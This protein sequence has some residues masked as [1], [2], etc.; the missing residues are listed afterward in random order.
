M[1]TSSVVAPEYAR[2]VADLRRADRMGPPPVALAEGNVVDRLHVD[3]GW[4]PG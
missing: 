4:P 1:S 3:P 2:F